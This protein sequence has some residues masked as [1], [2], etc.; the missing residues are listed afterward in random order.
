MIRGFSDAVVR[1]IKQGY[2]V[3]EQGELC[4]HLGE[5]VAPKMFELLDDGYTMEILDVP[6]HKGVS[7]MF[8]TIDILKDHVW[9]RS[10]TL[11][12]GGWLPRLVE[13]SKEFP[14]MTRPITTVYPREPLTGYSTIHGDPT[15][16]NFM[17][18]DGNPI[19]SDPMPRMEYR[20]E[21]PERCEVDWGKLVQS[22]YGWEN[23]LGCRHAMVNEVHLVVREMPDEIVT[24]ALLWGAIHLARVSKRADAKS[25]PA[26]AHWARQGSKSL[27]HHAETYL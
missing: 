2:G 6:E 16:A 21:V 10:P 27:A 9:E 15:L 22:A 5:S 20:W 11:P 12:V 4:Q 18:R 7:E 17:L 23:Q 19:L 1:V 25:L 3:R 13:W 24:P 26:I 14:W 8:D